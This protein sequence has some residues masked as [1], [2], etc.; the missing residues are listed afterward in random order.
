M[1][2]GRAAPARTSSSGSPAG[3][4]S[5]LARAGSTAGHGSGEIFVAFSTGLRIP[6]SPADPLLTT[7]HL[8]DDYL[9][10]SS[11]PPSRAIEEA[12]IDSLFV[13]DTVD[14]RAGD[15]SRACP[16]ERTL[17]LLARAGRLA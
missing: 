4:A 10:R 17:E 16:V 12:V 5:G 7:T 9:D 14:G 15:A 6:R 2:H 13:A 1:C 3:R 8:H 11:R